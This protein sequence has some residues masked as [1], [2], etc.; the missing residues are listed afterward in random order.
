MRCFVP[1]AQML[2]CWL[3]VRC[4]CRQNAAPVLSRGAP[5]PPPCFLTQK[6]NFRP[7]NL[8]AH[9]VPRH[10]EA[11]LFAPWQRS[12]GAPVSCRQCS[13]YPKHRAGTGEAM[14]QRGSM[15]CADA[16]ALVRSVENSFFSFWSYL[17]GITR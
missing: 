13:Q 9:F 15:G 16:Q 17:G 1:P 8:G 4:P 14:G 11:I 2:L 5:R 3:C 10:G 12:P 6:L 7:Q